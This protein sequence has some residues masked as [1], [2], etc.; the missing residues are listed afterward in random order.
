MACFV[1]IPAWCYGRVDGGGCGQG[2]EQ[3]WGELDLAGVAGD[4]L[5]KGVGDLAQEAAQLCNRAG[6]MYDRAVQ[7]FHACF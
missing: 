2:Q 4:F 6:P 3:L 1:T 5:H 7:L